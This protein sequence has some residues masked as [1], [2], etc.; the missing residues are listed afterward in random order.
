MKT[1]VLSEDGPELRPKYFG[2]I[3]NKNIVQ[4]VA[5]KYYIS[6]WNIEQTTEHRPFHYSI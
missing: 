5:I 6:K 4:Q 2:A 1:Y 3:I